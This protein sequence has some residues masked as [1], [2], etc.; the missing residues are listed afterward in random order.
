V[1]NDGT[2]AVV[3]LGESSLA[4][5]RFGSVTIASSTMAHG[6]RYLVT[7]DLATTT[8]LRPLLELWAT[9]VDIDSGEIDPGVGDAL[10]TALAGGSQALHKLSES[11]GLRD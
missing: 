5:R 1:W 4:L 8:G 9:A 7:V 2:R 6:R 10:L 3:V 11:P